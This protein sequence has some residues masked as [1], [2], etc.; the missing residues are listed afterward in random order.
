M[1]KLLTKRFS[2]Y[3]SLFT[4]TGTLI[5]CALPALFVSLGLGATLVGLTTAIPQ[6]IWISEHKIGV[7]ILGAVLLLAAGVLQ[8]QAK[9]LSCPPDA[10][11][12]EACRSARDFS[13]WIYW[14]SVALYGI[15]FS[16]AFLIRP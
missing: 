5:C 11:L 14:I 12:A 3:L 13:F 8:Y 6:L 4:S 10:K 7:F 9:N 1:E 15:G 2:T 16:F